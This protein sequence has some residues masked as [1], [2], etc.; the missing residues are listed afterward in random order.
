MPDAAAIPAGPR[1]APA[2]PAPGESQRLAELWKRFE[3]IVNTATDFFTLIDARFHYQAVNDAYCQAHQKARREIIGLHVAD[4][5]GREVFEGT[6]RAP[7]ERC[8]A[9]EESH[10]RSRFEFPRTG[11][12]FFEVSLYPYRD[13]AG[14]HAIAVTRDITAQHDAEEAL[15]ASEARYR[16]LIESANDVIFFLAP[17]GRVLEINPAFETLTGWS[18]A[19][20]LGRSFTLLLH[21]EDVPV[22]LQRFQAILAGAPSQRREYRVRKRSGEYAV[23]EF[24]LAPQIKDGCNQGMF[25]IGRDVTD[26]KR[27]EDAIVQS[28]EHYR[29]LFHQA[30]QMQ[31]NLRR[32]SAR[33]LEVQEQE[34][35]RISRDLHDEVGQSLTAIN[36]NIAALKKALDGAPAAQVRRMA[37]TQRLIEHTMVTVHNFAR[38][39]RP[40]MLDDLGLLP[41]LRNYVK[42]F[43][44]RTGLAL[45]LQ[46]RGA[47]DI[48]RLDAERKIVVYRVVQEALNNIVKHAAARRVSIRLSAN[49]HGIALELAD[50]GKGFTPAGDA[51][52]SPASERLGLL[53]LAE[54]V[55]LVSG[56]FAVESKP[57]RGTTVRATIPFKPV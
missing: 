17:D 24:T 4:L 50:D 22:A 47:A 20:W 49:R 56:E 34:R 23:G 31:E 26:R 14:A 27:V 21:P 13:D 39:L 36:M 16:A 6:L 53:G 42:G 41:T 54:R 37:D 52:A 30:Y 7:L 10:Y 57:G 28:E 9:G 12:R 40:A 51:A 18:R 3:T 29:D 46:A 38:E 33:I 55:R 19:E 15:R 35:T 48:E 32:L 25:G 43:G 44:G 11:P 2:A 1:P 45:R 8:F 5:W